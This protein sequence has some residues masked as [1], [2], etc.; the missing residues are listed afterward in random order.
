MAKATTKKGA[1][2][3]FK[4][5]KELVKKIVVGAVIL[6]LEIGFTITLTMVLKSP[7][8]TLSANSYA[9]GSI[10]AQGKAEENSGAIYTKQFVNVGGLRCRVAEGAEITYKVF[11]YDKAENFISGTGE[12]TTDF[13]DSLVPEKAEKVKI[14]ITPTADADGKVSIFEKGGYAGQLTV[15]SYK[16]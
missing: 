2:K 15:F 10:N 3:G 12:L 9:V 16:E 1:K 6:A 7:V 5:N 11:F 8:K 14:V 4:L 13:T